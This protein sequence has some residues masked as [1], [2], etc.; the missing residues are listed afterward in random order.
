MIHGIPEIAAY[1]MTA[2]A[3][4]MASLALTAYIGKRL[5]RDNFLKIVF[6]TALLVLLAVFVLVF[7]AG[8]EIYISPLI[9]S[10]I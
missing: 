5:S 10:L 2:M 6:R 1:F 4:G 8:L 9:A 7:A 3:G